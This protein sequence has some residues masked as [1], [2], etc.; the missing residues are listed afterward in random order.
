MEPLPARHLLLTAFEPFGGATI[1]ASLEVARIVASRSGCELLELPVVAG[2]AEQRLLDRL[3]DPDMPYPAVVVSLGEAGPELRVDLE[4]M[5]VNLDDFRIPDNA[6]NVRSSVPIDPG[7]P[8][9]HFATVDLPAIHRRVDGTTPVPVR[10]SRS[11]G[12]FVCNH[13]AF[14]VSNALPKAPYAFVHVPSWRRET[15]PIVLEG[16]ADTVAAILG[17][18]LDD[19]P[20]DTLRR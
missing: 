3:S 11:A 6:G 12:T 19:P 20:D 16:I 18:I 15:G 9:A 5:Y 17:A 7:G 14:A 2:L 10:L 4:L 1:N 8:P 13:L